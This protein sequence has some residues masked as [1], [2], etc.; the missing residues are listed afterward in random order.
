MADT[1]DKRPCMKND[2]KLTIHATPWAKRFRDDINSLKEFDEG[3]DFVCE[4]NGDWMKFFVCRRFLRTRFNF[5]PKNGRL[6]K[7][8][9]NVRSLVRK[10]TPKTYH[11]R[12]W[13]KEVRNAPSFETHKS[14]AAHEVGGT[15]VLKPY[16]DDFRC[17]SDVRNSFL[18][19]VVVR[20]H[21]V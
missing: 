4:L 1:D 16:N 5:D 6:Q 8:Q 7:Q 21:V 9:K 20:T 15:H 3:D 10:K 12:C 13:A 14:T 19:L 18:E 11:C 2:G 17:V